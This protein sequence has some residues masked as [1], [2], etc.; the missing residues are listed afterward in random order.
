MVPWFQ[1]VL[2]S[3][4]IPSQLYLQEYY[5]SCHLFNSNY[6]QT[7]RIIQVIGKDRRKRLFYNFSILETPCETGV[8]LH[9]IQTQQDLIFL[10]DSPWPQSNFK[11]LENI[12]TIN[13]TLHLLQNQHSVQTPFDSY[14]SMFAQLLGTV[15][16]TLV[17]LIDDLPGPF[18]VIELLGCWIRYSRSDFKCRPRLLLVSETF[19]TQSKNRSWLLDRLLRHITRVQH[20]VDPTQVHTRKDSEAMIWRCFESI[21]LLPSNEKTVSL[22]SEHSRDVFNKRSSLKWVFTACDLRQ[23]IQS[24]IP[25][26]TKERTEEFN[27]I[28]AI[29]E[30]DSD[31]NFR[32]QIEELVHVTPNNQ[33]INLAR[34]VASALHTDAYPK[35]GHSKSAVN[36]STD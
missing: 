13:S 36:L 9:S 3:S 30:C 11:R 14:V 18:A 32:S 29:R 22:I 26:F 15:S 23:I 7:P 28:I 4:C 24:A 10:I 31:K 34:S 35:Q 8:A 17:V 12:N 27:I 33:H 20:T 2:G 1:F 5:S 25:H 16:Q 19:N 21:E 6:N